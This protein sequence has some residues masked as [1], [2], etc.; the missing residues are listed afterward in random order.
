MGRC[1]FVQPETVTLQI[2][3]GDW[4]E[5]KKRLTTGE[6]R[7]SKA[8]LVKE[9]RQDGR[10]TPDFEM[11]G[12]AEVLAYLVDWSLKDKDGKP[13]RIDTDAKKRAAIDQLDDDTFEE[14]SDAIAAHVKA[15][16]EARAEAKKPKD[17]GIKSEAT[18]PSVD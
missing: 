16:E 11:V 5:V 15:E 6:S 2:S 8:V 12:I 9:V 17:G 10:M 4:I 13:S 3:D 14:I 7:R 1:R 18:S